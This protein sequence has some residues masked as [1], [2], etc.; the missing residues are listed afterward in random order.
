MINPVF[1]FVPFSELHLPNVCAL[2]ALSIN[3]TFRYRYCLCVQ[4]N[5]HTVPV[6]SD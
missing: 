1:L 6:P 2:A 4:K 3:T 5:Q